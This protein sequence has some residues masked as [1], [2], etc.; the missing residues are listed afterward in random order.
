[1]F[2]KP[3]AGDISFFSNSDRLQWVLRKSLKFVLFLVAQN[4][5]KRLLCDIIKENEKPSTEEE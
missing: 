2:N 3:T 4:K 1:M 5:S